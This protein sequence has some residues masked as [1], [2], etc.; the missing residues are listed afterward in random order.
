[1]KSTHEIR[2]IMSVIFKG[3]IAHGIIERNP[4]DIVVVENYDQ[5]HGKA[6]TKEEESKLLSDVSGTPR[7]ILYAICLYTGLRPNELRKPIRIEERLLIA[8]NS[9]R[10]GQRVEYK[11]IYIC[12]KLAAI[13]ENVDEIPMLHDKYLSTEFP[14]HCPGHKLYDLRVTF[15]TRCKELGVSDHARQHFMGHSLGAL[16]NAY[17][18]LSDEYL[19]KEG[20]KLNKW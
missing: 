5:E 9:K 20:M 4:L 1:M 14:K 12:D 16:G 19:I 7:G 3:A 15:N 13:L 2:S 6:L 10:K 17:T 8:V 18:D 11:R